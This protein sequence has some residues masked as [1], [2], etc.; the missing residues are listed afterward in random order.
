MTTVT[1]VGTRLAEA[2]EE[3]VY[4][5]EASGCAGC[6]YRDQCLNLTVGTRY[7]I[8]SVRQS[9]QT[10]DCAMHQDGVRAVEVEPAP[11]RANV[12]SKGA[13]AG[14]KASLMGP[15][16]HTECPSHPYCEPAGADFDDEYRIDEIIGD[17]PHDYCMLDRDL[18]LVELE[19]DEQ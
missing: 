14:S 10:L 3:F 15:C 2:G 17:P 12:P 19:G 16:P 9:G 7:R 13:Y 6:P 1:L 5:G 4:H 18:T 11:I 8:T